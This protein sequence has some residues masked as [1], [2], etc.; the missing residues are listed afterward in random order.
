MP[1]QMFR[2]IQVRETRAK[3]NELG[4]LASV[5]M[6]AAGEASR[7]IVLLVLAPGHQNMFIFTKNDGQKPWR[8]KLVTKIA[9]INM[10][11]TNR[12]QDCCVLV[13]MCDLR[14]V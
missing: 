10:H 5:A 12:N 14:V 6:W 7:P 9:N 3:T 11:K 4:D 8:C 1:P 2:S 13:C